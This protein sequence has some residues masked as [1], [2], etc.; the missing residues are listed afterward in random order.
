MKSPE[1]KAASTGNLIIRL[2]R[3]YNVAKK[4]A[5]EEE[6]KIAKELKRRHVIPDLE[7]F[8]TDLNSL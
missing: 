2:C 4:S 8:L 7:G 6:I 5:R 1:I 3:L